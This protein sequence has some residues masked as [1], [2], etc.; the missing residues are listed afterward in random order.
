MKTGGKGIEEIMLRLI[1]S[2]CIYSAH[3]SFVSCAPAPLRNVNVI[4]FWFE[5]L[6]G[7]R[8]IRMATRRL[9][10]SHKKNNV[11]KLFFCDRFLVRKLGG[12]RPIR[13]ATRR[14]DDSRQKNYE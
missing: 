1:D 2:F 9:D 10:D 8:P 7:N 13:M 5:S 14:L 4:D 6:G 11:Q 12:N 3:A